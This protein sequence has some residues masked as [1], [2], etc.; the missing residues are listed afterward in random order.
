M[1]KKENSYRYNRPLPMTRREMDN[2]GW[3]KCDIILISGDAYVDHPSFGIALIGRLL[4]SLGYRVGIIA[5]PYIRNIECFRVLG[6]PR[7]FW[8]I[9]AGNVDSQLARLT[10][11]RKLRRDD[12]YS[13]NGISGARPSNASIVYASMARQAFKGI[14]VVIGGIEASLRRFAYYDYWTDKVKRSLI[15]D[16]KADLIAFGMAEHAIAEITQRLDQGKNLHGIRGTAEIRKDTSGIDDLIVLPSY[17][18]VLS[19]DNKGKSSY[20]AMSRL[21]HDHHHVNSKATLVQRHADRWL[22]V[23]PPALPL[24]TDELDHLYSLPFTRRPHPSY[25]KASIP[26]YE[27]IKD[28]IT[29]HRGCYA[30]CSFCAITSHQGRT[31]TSRSKQN[32]LREIEMLSADPAFH[33]TIS[34]IGGPTANMYATGCKTGY[35]GCQRHNCLFPAIC[36]NLEVDHSPL[37]DL[38]RSARQIKGIKHVFVTSGIR[39]DLALAGGGEKYIEE[40]VRHHV[41]GLLKIAPEHISES[42]L[43]VMHKPPQKLYRDFV[44]IFYRQVRKANR[45]YA[46]V[47]YFMSGHPGCTL[48]DMIELAIYLRKTGIKPEQIQDF[49]PAP[50]TLANCMF[51]TGIDPLTNRKMHVAQTDREKALQRA[52]LLSHLPE[53]HRKVREAL[54][55][56]GRPDLIGNGHD[57]LVTP[58]RGSGSM[59][60]SKTGTW[61]NHEQHH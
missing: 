8:G 28:S 37:L 25:G 58:S 45:K 9:T 60:R 53:F 52:I 24:T 22:V 54:I 40:L 3:D 31:V 14:P 36:K 12:A 59:R 21:I 26:A 10:V 7:L 46:I 57:H 1:N 38:M 33:G 42:V 2:L 15:F 17:E 55:E 34:D 43:A 49:Y 19:P 61:R 16:A 18:E 27:M 41:C 35:S 4:E 51:Y 56:A 32:I 48:N 13:P 6:I 29:T 39:F 11:M 23:N 30:E 44:D 47:E 50:L 20:I 5:Q